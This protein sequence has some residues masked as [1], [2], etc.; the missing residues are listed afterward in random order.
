MLHR[1]YICGEK[2]LQK[3]MDSTI[4]KSYK[5]KTVILGNYN[6]GIDVPVCC[7]M[8]WNFCFLHI[9]V[10]GNSLGDAVDS[11]YNELDERT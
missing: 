5:N 4:I 11:Y 10:M 3:T 9:S 6:K 8:E 1:H 2:K 7:C